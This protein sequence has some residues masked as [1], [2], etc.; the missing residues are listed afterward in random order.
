MKWQYLTVEVSASKHTSDDYTRILN[1]KGIY[2]WKLVAVTTKY[3]S[4][5]YLE[6]HMFFFRKR[7]TP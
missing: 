3:S 6:S 5:G 1:E 4:G 7:L 2:G